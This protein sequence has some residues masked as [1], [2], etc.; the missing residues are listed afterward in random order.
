[1]ERYSI[2]LRIQFEWGKIWTRKTQNMDTL[3]TESF[4]SIYR[5]SKKDNFDEFW[6]SEEGFIAKNKNREKIL[7]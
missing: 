1:M 4:W 7:E 3:R 5:D 6:L 2:S